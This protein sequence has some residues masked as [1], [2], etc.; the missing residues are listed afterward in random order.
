MNSS[1]S[2]KSSAEDG[3]AK[4]TKV[5]LILICLFV[6]VAFAVELI[7]AQVPDLQ[8]LSQLQITP[9]NFVELQ[10]GRA[11]V[12]Q[13][14]LTPLGYA[15]AVPMN[16]IPWQY[17]KSTDPFVSEA[18]AM[19]GNIRYLILHK[20]LTVTGNDEPMLSSLVGSPINVWF[21][22]GKIVQIASKGQEYF[23][24]SRFAAGMNTIQIKL[25]AGL[26]FALL[27]A[28]G[29]FFWAKLKNVFKK[30]INY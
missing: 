22:E 29:I 9:V 7:R 14:E 25:S 21:F 13:S 1:E 26:L 23:P 2:N 16:S 5:G 4:H 27:A 3:M 18:A 8:K 30:F 12:A 17:D 6:A 20:A 28:F 19:V 24:A 15:Y 11:R 10:G